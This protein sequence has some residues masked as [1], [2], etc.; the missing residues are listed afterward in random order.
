MKENMQVSGSHLR[1]RKRDKMLF[2]GRKMLRKV[3]TISGQAYNGHGRKRLR[4]Y[5]IPSFFSAL[6]MQT[7]Q[8]TEEQ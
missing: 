3:K 2:Y 4:K 8:F 1:F 7:L 6:I 5:K